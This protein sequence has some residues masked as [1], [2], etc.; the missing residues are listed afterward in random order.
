[1]GWFHGFR[2]H[3]IEND[4]GEI[5]DFV[6]TQGNVDDGEPLKEGYMLNRIFGSLDTDKGYPSKNLAAMLFDDGLHLVKEIRNN[7]KNVLIALSD[8]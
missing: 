3:I 5:L 7:M 2:L 4:C 6:I 1:M 8:Q